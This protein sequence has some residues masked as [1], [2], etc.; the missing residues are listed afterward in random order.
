[1]QSVIEIGVKAL[2]GGAL[3][4]AF[5]LVA[6]VFTPKTFSGIFSAAPSVALAGLGVTLVAK[7]AHDAALASQGMILG[8]VALLLYC[9]VAVPA[10][11][12]FGALR[13]AGVSLVAWLL[14]ALPG[15]L[16]WSL[17]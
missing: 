15:V 9:L 14:V 10:L 2:F 3:V 13:G 17:A 11:R 4:V 1:M 16:I 5:S 6:E 12:R 8:A 7:T